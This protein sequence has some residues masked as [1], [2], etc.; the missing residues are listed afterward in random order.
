MRSGGRETR[1]VS[2]PVGNADGG[3]AGPAEKTSHGDAVSS[4]AGEGDL[5]RPPGDPSGATAV[6]A[7]CGDPAAAAD[8]AGGRKAPTHSAPSAAAAKR[9][10][11]GTPA[12]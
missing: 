9:R 8:P 10:R 2:G 3:C 11:R 1:F 6:I 7:A 5:G 12:A 4:P